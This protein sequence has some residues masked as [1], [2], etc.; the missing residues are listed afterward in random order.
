MLFNNRGY[1]VVFGVGF[2]HETLDSEDV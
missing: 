1:L 2:G